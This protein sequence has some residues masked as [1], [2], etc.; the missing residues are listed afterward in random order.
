MLNY[1]G[2]IL[3][4]RTLITQFGLNILVTF[5]NII[6]QQCFLTGDNV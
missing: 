6:H 3:K 2:L 4:T 1:K 5:N